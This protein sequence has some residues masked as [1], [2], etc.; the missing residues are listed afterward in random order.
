M[1]RAIGQR[2]MTSSRNIYLRFMDLHASCLALA[3]VQGCGSSRFK[4]LE[5]LFSRHIFTF[6]YLHHLI[7]LQ[8]N[9][10]STSE[11]TP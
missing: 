5:T 11:R 7:R 9:A 4:A 2:A 6:L 10:L 8:R 1:G 3:F